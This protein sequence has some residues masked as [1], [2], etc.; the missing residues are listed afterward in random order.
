M[1]FRMGLAFDTTGWTPQGLDQNVLTWQDSQGDGLGLYQ[2]DLPPDL[3]ASL[4][5][6][7][8]FWERWPESPSVAVLRKFV[9]LDGVPALK[10]INK[11]P[12]EPSGVLYQGAY[13]VPRQAFS[14]VLKLQCAEWGT[15]GVRE[16]VVA[17]RMLQS[18]E[19]VIGPNGTV[20]GW[21]MSSQD[22]VNAKP[23]P[24]EDERLDAEF[25]DHPLSRLR[26][27]LRRLEPT[28]QVAD[29][30]K[31]ASPFTGPSI[32][33]PAKPWWKRIRVW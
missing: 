26:N 10:I 31:Q 12:Q 11:H 7:V 27:H 30:I 1:G 6:E 9:L 28:I 4:E 32:K 17:A 5:D 14:Y 2:F 3:P 18:G 33:E 13:I 23:N 16:A 8:R 22:A 19:L 15:T 21:P 20:S 24:A 25:P 29:F